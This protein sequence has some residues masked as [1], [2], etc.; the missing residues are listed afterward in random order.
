MPSA[1]F[2]ILTSFRYFMLLYYLNY[3]LVV[4]TFVHLPAQ[5]LLRIEV[6][7]IWGVWN[8]V[9]DC[10]KLSVHTFQSY[11]ETKQPRNSLGISVLRVAWKCLCNLIRAWYNPN[12]TLSYILSRGMCSLYVSDTLNLHSASEKNHW[13]NK[14]KSWMYSRPGVVWMWCVNKPLINWDQVSQSDLKSWDTYLFS[15]IPFCS[16]ALFLVTF[17]E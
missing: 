16:I 13:L 8:D 3:K 10:K 4:G 15:A 9:G 6:F 7:I 12:Y 17:D 2:P 1:S 14:R 5:F 11:R